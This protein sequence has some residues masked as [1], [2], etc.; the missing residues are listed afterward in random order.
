MIFVSSV[1]LRQFIRYRA[2]KRCQLDST[3]TKHRPDS[4]HRSASAD[5]PSSKF[6]T[7]QYTRVVPLFLFPDFRP[8]A[9]VE[10]RYNYSALCFRAKWRIVSR[11]TF[12]GRS[13]SLRFASF[14]CFCRRAVG[15]P[16]SLRLLSDRCSS[17]FSLAPKVFPRDFPLIF[18]SPPFF[19]CSALR[20]L[21]VR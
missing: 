9:L 17:S 7:V 10:N 5:S 11:R 1:K 2:Q 20:L 8:A 13:I 3:K 21:P 4:L 19:A 14:R 18:L 15:F 6:S 16:Q 12:R